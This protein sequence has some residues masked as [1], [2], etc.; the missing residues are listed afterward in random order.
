MQINTMALYRVQVVAT[1]KFVMGYLSFCVFCVLRYI[2]SQLFTTH[3]AYP[4]HF[5]YCNFYCFYEQPQ[6]FERFSC[7]NFDTIVFVLRC[8]L[9]FKTGLSYFSSLLLLLQL[10]LFKLSREMSVLVAETDTSSRLIWQ[11]MNPPCK[12]ACGMAA[13]PS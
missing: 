7:N 13:S 2:C 5:S 9:P 6:K 11:P 10:L 1:T 4:F 8:R 12:Q 3:F